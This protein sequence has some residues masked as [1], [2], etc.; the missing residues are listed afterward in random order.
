MSQNFE[1]KTILYLKAND[2]DG[3][4]IYVHV[5]GARRTG[6]NQEGMDNTEH[7]TRMPSKVDYFHEEHGKEDVW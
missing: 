5:G 4:H 1:I 6:E 3:T 7:I 2:F